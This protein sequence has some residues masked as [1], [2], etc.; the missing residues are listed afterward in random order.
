[1]TTLQEKPDRHTL[2]SFGQ[3]LNALDDGDVHRMCSEKMNEVIEALAVD[4]AEH[5]G[6]PT[7]SLTIKLTFKMDGAT[8]DVLPE[9]K[10]KVPEQKLQRSPFWVTPNSKLSSANRVSKNSNCAM[11]VRASKNKSTTFN[12]KPNNQPHKES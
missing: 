5:R 8:I 9:V 7:G 10:H 3:L 1:M 4:H 12:H 6:R 11:L 2:K